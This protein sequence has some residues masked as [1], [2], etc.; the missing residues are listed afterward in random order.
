LFQAAFDK[1]HATMVEGKLTKRPKIIW[2][3]HF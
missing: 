2:I 3:E 1:P